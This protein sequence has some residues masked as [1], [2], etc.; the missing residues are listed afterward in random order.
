[1]SEDDNSFKLIDDVSDYVST[2][3]IVDL[4]SG[5]YNLFVSL[6]EYLSIDFGPVQGADEACKY[7]E[8][9]SAQVREA[10]EEKQ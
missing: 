3:I 5:I 7:L 6:V 1:M 10:F 4:K 9:L 8:R 2:D